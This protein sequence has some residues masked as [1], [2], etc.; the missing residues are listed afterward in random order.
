[1]PGSDGI[2]HHFELRSRERRVAECARSRL[3]A[4]NLQ[5]EA[6]RSSLCNARW[7]GMLKRTKQLPECSLIASPRGDVARRTTHERTT[8]GGSECAAPMNLRPRALGIDEPQKQGSKIKGNC[9]SVPLKHCLHICFGG[10][11]PFV[12]VPLRH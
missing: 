2:A 8:F 3:T 11:R 6:Q 9:T 4:G 12:R 10:T 1:M 5:H 7:L